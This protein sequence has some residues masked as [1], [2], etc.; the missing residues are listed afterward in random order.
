MTFLYVILGI[1][2]FFGIMYIHLYNKMQESIIRIDEAEARIDNNLRDKFDLLNRII[3]LYK[4][5]FFLFFCI[6][7]IAV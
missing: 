6:I 2:A 1:I 5:L 7:I 3:N 4:L